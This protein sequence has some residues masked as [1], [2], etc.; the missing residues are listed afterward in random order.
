MWYKQDALHQYMLRAGETNNVGLPAGGLRTVGGSD[1]K[2]GCLNAPNLA[3]R[4]WMI[5]GE[6]LV[7]SPHWKLGSAE[8]FNC[9]KLE[10]RRQVDSFCLLASRLNLLSEFET[11]KQVDSA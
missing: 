2:A 5:P 10:G 1:H 6:L 9:S 4:A 11:I 7:F 3:L 8:L